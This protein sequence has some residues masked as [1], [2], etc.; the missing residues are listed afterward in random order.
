MSS[1]D[2]AVELA[3]RPYLLVTSLDETTEGEPIYFARVI[4]LEGCFGQ[5]ETPEKAVVDLRLAMIDFIESL[6]DD[7]LPVPDAVGSFIPEA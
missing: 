1:R 2:K 3:K 6:L 5:G 4:E 7:A